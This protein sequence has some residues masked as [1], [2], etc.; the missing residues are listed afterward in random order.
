M[1]IRAECRLPIS[2][3]PTE[4]QAELTIV[5]TTDDPLSPPITFP[6][7]IDFMNSLTLTLCIYLLALL[8]I[9][10]FNLLLS[11]VHRVLKNSWDPKS[12]N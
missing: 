9:V 2:Y 6:T 11:L 8:G 5:D 4:E 3:I 7:Y 12:A 1:W 10:R